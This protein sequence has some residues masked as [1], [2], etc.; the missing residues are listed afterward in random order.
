M[1]KQIK[2]YKYDEKGENGVVPGAAMPEI[3]QRRD[4]DGTVECCE[5]DTSREMAAHVVKFW[6][7]DFGQR[8]YCAKHG[9]VVVMRFWFENQRC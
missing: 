9:T 2:V 6:H 4:M 7:I 5:I 8:I 1:P 3:W